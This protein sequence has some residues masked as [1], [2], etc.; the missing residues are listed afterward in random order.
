M[1]LPTCYP[2]PCMGALLG[3]I[4]LLGSCG[5][6]EMVRSTYPN[7][8]LMAE[9]QVERR[10]QTGAWVY[11]YPSGLKQT[12][13]SWLADK[14]IGPWTWW[15]EDGAPHYQGAYVAG[16]LREGSWKSWHPDGKLASEG[17]YRF[18]RQD[19]IWHYW[20]PDGMPFAE[21]TFDLGV[22]H[23]WWVKRNPDGSP[24]ECGLFIKGLKVGRWTTW[25]AGQPTVQ[26]LGAPVGATATWKGD[27][28]SMSG[29]VTATVIFDSTG[30]PLALSLHNDGRTTTSLPEDLSPFAVITG[31]E[32][33]QP[34]TPPSV[35][36]AEPGE[37]TVQAA[38]LALTT[39]SSP[40][41]ASAPVQA[42]SDSQIEQ[43]TIGLSP[44]PVIPTLLAK[45]DL[46]RSS[47]LIR[48]Y[49][50]G[51]DPL[52]TGNIDQ[53]SGW[54]TKGG[55]PAAR[56]LL[57]LHMPQER[58]LSSTGSVI[59][60]KRYQRPVVVVIMR[61]FSGQVCI[62]CATQTAAIAN[63]YKRFTEAGGEVVIIYPGPTE[64]V[65][66][67][68]QAVQ[69]LRKDP[70]P[71]DIGLDVSLLLV[72]GLGIEENLAKPTSL[73]LDREG[74]IAFAYIG[75]TMADRPSVDDL[76]HALG[77]VVK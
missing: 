44:T 13:G 16:G 25:A 43:P 60:L 28:W 76:L 37:T 64:S 63:N 41:P 66:A 21:G 33:Q 52:S 68:V 57:G 30:I 2:L 15:Y 73:V 62:Y 32:K 51:P 3:A 11:F 59:D 14:Q 6:P 53:W 56:K 20:H 34:S 65:P 31:P 47:E 19:G 46:S 8:K 71:M 45:G 23:G 10:Q 24:Q 75:A 35:E 12:A 55:D 4:L 49:T 74:N 61:G 77:K 70:P 18:D 29:S 67:F 50:R 22:K 48:G 72:R 38:P 42:T 54:Q 9:G 26:E 69:T 40:V 1:P 58:F 17:S 7:G 36:M 27:T 5:G 39:V